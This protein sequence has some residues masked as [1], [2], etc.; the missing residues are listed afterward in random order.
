MFLQTG[1]RAI[2][3][4]FQCLVFF[5]I[6]SQNY[7]IYFFNNMCIIYRCLIPVYQSYFRIKEGVEK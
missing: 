4:V 1:N 3:N 7:D 5:D 2:L 6:Y